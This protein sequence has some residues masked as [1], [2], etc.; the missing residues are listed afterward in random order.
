MDDIYDYLH[1]KLKAFGGTHVGSGLA[2]EYMFLVFFPLVFV[3]L[4]RGLNNIT[5]AVLA[6]LLTA[7]IAITMPLV[8]R[9]NRENNYHF[10]TAAFYV[11]IVMGLVLF[12]IVGGF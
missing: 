5:V 7:A 10:N 8:L 1:D 4:V 12:I 3:A 2:A 6:I 11:A 9:A